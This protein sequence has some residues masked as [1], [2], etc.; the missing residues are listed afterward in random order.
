MSLYDLNS[1]LYQILPDD[2]FFHELDD[3]NLSY[4]PSNTMLTSRQGSYMTMGQTSTTQNSM[5]NS[6]HFDLLQSSQTYHVSISQAFTKSGIPKYN[7]FKGIE[8]EQDE[9]NDVLDLPLHAGLLEGEQQPMS[10][11]AIDRSKSQ[12]KEMESFRLTE[13]PLIDLDELDKDKSTSVAEPSN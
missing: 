13:T 2:P 12:L 8:P 7:S 5:E 10:S 11:F 3:P 1:D 9:S 6:A 4:I